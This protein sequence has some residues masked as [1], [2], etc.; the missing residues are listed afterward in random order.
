[1][2]AIAQPPFCSSAPILTCR[3]Q[4]T[5]WSRSRIALPSAFTSDSRSSEW[6]QSNSATASSALFDCSWPIRWSSTSGYSLRNAG[7]FVFRLLH[8]IFTKTAVT[9]GKQRTDFIGGAGFRHRDQRDVR[10]LAPGDFGGG[11]DFA[12]DCCKSSGV[13][14]AII[15]RYSGG[16]AASASH[17]MIP[18]IWLMTDPRLGDG[19]LAAIR[20]IADWLWRGVSALSIASQGKARGCSTSAADMPP[21]RT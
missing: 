16:D 20:Q 13:V 11:G 8:T 5:G 3:K 7:H 2:S 4:G 6:M 10:W 1:M 12:V 21:A 14:S 17:P 15:A 19:L 18:K 9:G